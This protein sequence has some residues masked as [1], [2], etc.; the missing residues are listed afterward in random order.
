MQ[1]RSP[2]KVLRAQI[3]QFKGVKI[4]ESV[5]SVDVTIPTVDGKG[6][7]VVDLKSDEIAGLLMASRAE[8]I[9]YRPERIFAG[10]ASDRG[11]TQ[12]LDKE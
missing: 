2:V 4:H 3:G 7:E 8:G 6:L 10:I 9:F 1:G 11:Q 5:D 12:I